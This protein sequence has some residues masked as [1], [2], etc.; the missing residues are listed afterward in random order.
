MHP[1]V[2]EFHNQSGLE[3]LLAASDRV[4]AFFHAETAGQPKKDHVD[5][6]YRVRTG[7]FGGQTEHTWYYVTT[8]SN[9][10]NGN[11]R[12]L[13]STVG[14]YDMPIGNYQYDIISKTTKCIGIE[15][16]ETM[17]VIPFST[18]VIDELVKDGK[19][20]GKTVFGA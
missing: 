1:K 19:I 18:D 7:S 20:D 6:I 3:Y 12:T 4:E 15:S 16:F 13:F 9:D 8:T 14:K 2:A 10:E 17:Y 5:Q 11:K